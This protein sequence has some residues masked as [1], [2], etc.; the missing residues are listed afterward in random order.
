LQERHRF[1]SFTF[2]EYGNSARL[3]N[4]FLVLSKIGRIRARWSRS[5]QGTPKMVTISHE[6]DGW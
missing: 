5:I 4:G 3:D 6:A 1:H 2:K